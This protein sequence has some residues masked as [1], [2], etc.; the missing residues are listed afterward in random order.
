MDAEELDKLYQMVQ[1]IGVTA[2][3]K[4]LNYSKQLIHWRVK[5]HPDYKPHRMQNRPHCP[6]CES[7]RTI[8]NGK[9]KKG[10]QRFICRSCNHQWRERVTEI[11]LSDISEKLFKTP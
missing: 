9:D 11:R 2:T 6:N 8:G 1:E 10:V 7:D 5:K 3:A 4:K